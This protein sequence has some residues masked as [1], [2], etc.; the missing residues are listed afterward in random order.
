[1][2]TH[3]HAHTHMHAAHMHMRMADSLFEAQ[4]AS[5]LAI[6]G[7]IFISEGGALD[8]Q[9]STF[10][11][12]AATDGGSG[13]AIGVLADDVPT[14][15]TIVDTLFEANIAKAAQGAAWAGA[16]HAQGSSANVS[17][18]RS[19][20]IDNTVGLDGNAGFGGAIASTLFATLSVSDCEFEGNVAQTWGGAIWSDSTTPIIIEDSTFSNN[21]SVQQN[22]GA[23][24]SGGGQQM[25]VSNC[26]FT[27]NTSP[28]PSDGTGAAIFVTSQANVS[29]S[30]SS[31][32][33]NA[34]GGAYGAI[35]IQ[36]AFTELRVEDCSFE[37]NTAA[38]TTA[39]AI[40]TDGGE[41]CGSANDFANE[42]VPQTTVPSP[43]PPCA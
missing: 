6:G 17:V 43:L 39:T 22:G 16:V 28:D 29:I 13:G 32:T 5:F 40:F 34:A 27:N 38:T 26:S 25:S 24:Y 4:T 15:V 3:W 20:F 21:T 11:G 31:F 12:C 18:S 1:M 33:A 41:T 8:V 19:T 36:S 9:N 37:G 30:D 23:L 14:G 42:P 2:H 10:R 35:V 7:A